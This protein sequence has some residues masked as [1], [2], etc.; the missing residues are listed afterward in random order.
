[1]APDPPA[2]ESGSGSD[3]DED[4]QSVVSNSSMMA[5]TDDFKVDL[6]KAIKDIKTVEKFAFD[7]EIEIPEDFNISV[8]GVG[9]IKPPL[10]KAQA[11]KIITQARQAP[12]GRGSDTIVDTS[13]RK[14][15]GTRS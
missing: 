8:Q 6:L 13:V 7:Q 14:N 11:V 2:T 12:F 1:M 9:D 3:N 4:K 15:L 5:T 10:K